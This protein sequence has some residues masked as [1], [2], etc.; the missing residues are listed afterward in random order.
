MERMIKNCAVLEAMIQRCAGLDVHKKCIVA[1]VSIIDEQNKIQRQVRTFS[2]MTR[3]LEE[4]SDWL[5]K[6][7]VSHVAMESTGVLWKPVFNILEEHFTILLCNARHIKAVPGR[8]TDVKDCEWIAQLL[9][10][11]LV[12]GSFI[13]PRAQRDLR[14]LTRQRAQLNNEKSREVNRIHKILEDANI[15]LSCVATDIL[16]ASG[17]DM[18]RALISGQTNEVELAEL[19]RRRLRGKIPELKEALHGHLTEHHRYMLALHLRHI[20]TVEGM[21]ADLDEHIARMIAGGELDSKPKSTGPLT[22][23]KE[24]S[25]HAEPP[26]Q[27]ISDQPESSQQSALGQREPSA[28]ALVPGHLPFN[29]AIQIIDGISGLGVQSAIDILAEIGVDMSQFPSDKHISSWAKVCPGNDESAGKRKS[30]KTGRGNPWLRRVLVQV[31]W[32][33]SHTDSYLGA[34]Y[35]RLARTRGKKRS[36]IAVAHSIL[37]IIYH[38]LSRGIEYHDLGADFFDHIDPARITK[39]FV[40]R[41]ESLGYTVSLEKITTVA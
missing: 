16:G 23:A 6:E 18:L 25:P 5:L 24:T 12:N 40:K 41:L 37:I 38:L 10:H 39:Y 11:G 34:M 17:R 32:A 28:P 31:A 2:T 36:I 33:A 26:T 19:A 9:Q 27:A 15:K 14:D 13:P 1:C 7:Q 4:L 20:E 35:R 30:G 21:I 29:K 3:N 8:K 22:P